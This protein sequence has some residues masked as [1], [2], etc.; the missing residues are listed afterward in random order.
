MR[1]L[2]EIEL[3]L[4]LLEKH[5]VDQ[6]RSEYPQIK[7]KGQGAGAYYIWCVKEE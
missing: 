6:L 4:P 2:Q 7:I 5:R 3:V 1:S